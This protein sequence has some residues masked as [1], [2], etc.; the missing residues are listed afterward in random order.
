MKLMKHE[1]DHNDKSKVCFVVTETKACT[2]YKYF[3]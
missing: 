1:L 3:F 2:A